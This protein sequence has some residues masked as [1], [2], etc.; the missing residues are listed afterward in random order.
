MAMVFTFHITLE[1]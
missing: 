1:S